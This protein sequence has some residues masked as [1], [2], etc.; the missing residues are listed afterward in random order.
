MKYYADANNVNVRLTASAA[1]ITETATNYV[2]IMIYDTVTGTSGAG[3]YGWWND[4]KGN[5]EFA[6]EHCG[7]VSGT[8]L[9][10]NIGGTD[11]A[12]EKT[13]EGDVVTW[14]FAIPR[15]VSDVLKNSEAYIGILAMK[16][17]DATGAM[18]D[19]YADMLKVTL[20]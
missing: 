17:W 14:T 15:S 3:F 8:D 1:K 19:K 11:V 16:D 6:A 7:V 5:T 2:T 20:P 12:V 18:P 10:L 13:E 4:A 9:T